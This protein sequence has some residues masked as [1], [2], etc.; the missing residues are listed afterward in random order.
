MLRP[1]TSGLRNWC[2]RSCSSVQGVHRVLVKPWNRCGLKELDVCYSVMCGDSDTRSE[3]LH[4]YIGDNSFFVTRLRVSVFLFCN[5]KRLTGY[6]WHKVV[7]NGG[8]L[9]NAVVWH[10]KMKVNNEYHSGSPF[11]FL[12]YQN[13]VLASNV[14]FSYFKIWNQNIQ[15]TKPKNT[16]RTRRA[17]VNLL[18]SR[19][20]SKNRTLY[21]Y[22][23]T[24]VGHSGL[25]SIR[26][27]REQ[28]KIEKF[29]RIRIYPLLK[30]SKRETIIVRLL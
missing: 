24:I 14:D 9:R 7:R 28:R 3:L 25:V 12:L 23:L 16:S 22:I 8:P 10:G 21:I 18:V 30:Q 17:S 26:R 27:P 4:S 2:L 6:C 15:K 29:K 13:F 11:R 1:V 20:R 5:R 19:S